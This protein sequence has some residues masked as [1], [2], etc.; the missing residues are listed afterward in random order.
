MYTYTDR[1][2]SI[3]KLAWTLNVSKLILNLGHNLNHGLSVIQSLTPSPANFFLRFSSWSQYK[4][5]IQKIDQSLV[6]FDQKWFCVK[7]KLCQAYARHSSDAC[8]CPE[9]CTGPL[10]KLKWYSYIKWNR[11]SSKL[12]DSVQIKEMLSYTSPDLLIEWLHSITLCCLMIASQSDFMKVK[13]FPIH[14][15]KSQFGMSGTWTL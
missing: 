10:R 5:L 4:K 15:Q 7:F 11:S 8:F 12:A 9:C 6:M 14:P 13:E 2:I 1:H 3:T